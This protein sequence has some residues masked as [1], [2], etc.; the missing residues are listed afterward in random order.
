MVKASLFIAL[1][2]APLALAAEAPISERIQYN[3]DVRPIL[4]D[5]CFRCH[6]FDKNKRE[7]DR[8]LDTREGALAENDGV[9]AI[10]PGK[11]A[12][13][14]AHVRIRS[15]DK[16]EMMP[17]PKANRQLS[18]REKQVLDR[19]IEQGAEYQEHWAYIPVSRPAV[20][21]ANEPGFTRNAIDQFILARQ[22]ELGLQH[23]GTADRGT[24]ARR[25]HLD[26][27]GLPPTPEEVEDFA[28][29]RSPDAYEKQV[30]W[31]LASPQFGERMAV[32]WLD[33]VRYADSIG[34]HSDNPRNVWPYRDYVIRAFNQNKP[35]DRFTIE[36][37]AGDLLPEANLEA[38]VASG[39]NRLTLTTEEGGAQAK[40]YEH[41]SVVDRVKSIGTSWLGQTFMCAE[42]H[43][44]KFDPIK[45]RDF[46]ALGAF[47]A[48][49]SEAPIGRREDGMLVPTPD[50]EK[51]L[52][53]LDA[54]LA[55]LR[56]RLNAPSPELEAA[57][58]AWERANAEGAADVPWTTAHI[59][60]ATADKA[61]K[62][63]VRADDTVKVEVDGSPATDTYQ[64]GIK[65]P[66]GATGIRLDVL[67]STTLP[68]NGPGRATNGN[69]VLTE[70]VV[71]REH[72]PLK[73][74]SATATFEQPNHTA[75][76][77]IDGNSD[78]KDNG[79]GVNGNAG[80]ESALYVELSDEIAKETTV[81]VQLRQ[82]YGDNHTIGKFRLSVTMA[83]KPIR[84]PNAAFPADVLAGLKTAPDQRTPEQKQKIFSYFRGIVPELAQL[85]AEIAET[86][87]QRESLVN[88]I[89]RCLVTESSKNLRT[90]RVLPRGNW[91]DDGGDAL[92]PAMPQFLPG[93]KSSTPTERLTRLDLAKWL[94]SR[95]NP[96]TARVLVNRLWKLFYGTG[97]SKTL[98]DMGTQGEIP[99]NQAL[100]DWLAVELM[101]SGWDVKHIVRLMV[102]SGTYRFA[103]IAP[104][105][106]IERDPFNRELTRASRWRLD[107]EFVRDN[108]LTISGLLVQQ[109]GGPSVKPYQ[110]AGYWEN[111]NFPTREWEPDKDRNQ[112]RR[113]L[114]TWWQRSYVQ[115]SLLAFDAPTREECAADRTRSNIPQQAL[116]LLN[117]PTYVEAARS[118]AK[119]MIKE[120]GETPEQRIQ[121]AWRKASARAP[122]AEEV[123]ILVELY[124]K[125]LDQYAQA[126][127]DAE[128]I[129]KVGFSPAAS[130]ASKAELAAYTGVARAILNLHETITRL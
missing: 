73:L 57:Q 84:A 29:A 102:T 36:Q 69:F 19:W 82:K 113:G 34:Y 50:Q 27:M 106:L 97:L 31:L 74:T 16:E 14:D 110:P 105:D 25:L 65:L 61:S 129:I 15:T 44:H 126:E 4:A 76:E 120:G 98:E 49:V 87:K 70:I 119:R 59:E 48:D 86:D 123:Q 124:K 23:V 67:P 45:T 121:W 94:V 122:K 88:S 64:L 103:S 116:A 24:L 10:V 41:K 12:E 30:E 75:K 77:A 42:C 111:L 112:W 78:G 58:A 35:F 118:L 8:R 54:S 130:D 108:A 71:E 107:A 40:E 114:Y 63:V 68:A 43:D 101:D 91:M 7:A 79:W 81:T 17:P 100:L 46:Y 9:R 18:K 60:S 83:P 6:G 39:Y 125:H 28:N 20:P 99:T 26:L 21:D 22:R 96:L 109:V 55:T 33:L 5:A 66:A 62:L 128:E 3:R 127:K 80:K 1:S 32:W 47:F 85:R 11:L 53:Q 93:A 72:Q 51:N 92:L 90:V 95:D 38:R 117:D 2:I 104:K 89:G 115:P 56:G 37:I 52:K 13:S